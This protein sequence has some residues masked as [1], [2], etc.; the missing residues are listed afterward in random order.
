MRPDQ[1][2]VRPCARCG[3]AWTPLRIAPNTGKAICVNEKACRRRIR[4]NEIKRRRT[5]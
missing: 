4:R 1:P 3:H 5:R 2:P